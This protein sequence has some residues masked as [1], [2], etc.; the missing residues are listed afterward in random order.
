MQNVLLM[1]IIHKNT[2]MSYLL[3][4]HGPHSQNCITCLWLRSYKLKPPPYLWYWKYFLFL[5]NSCSFHQFIIYCFKI[6]R[7][8][9]FGRPPLSSQFCVCA[10]FSWHTCGSA[11]QCPVAVTY[12]RSWYLELMLTSFRGTFVLVSV[13][14]RGL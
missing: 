12:A 8:E 7:K 2:N 5:D 9:R 3:I 11:D 13:L 10:M 1:S 4:K 14:C 6:K